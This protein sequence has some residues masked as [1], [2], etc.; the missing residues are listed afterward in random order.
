MT[1]SNRDRANHQVIGAA[2]NFHRRYDAQ[3]RC[4][5]ARNLRNDNK[6]L[7]RLRAQAQARKLQVRATEIHIHGE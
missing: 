1:R 3:L 6:R 2:S 4:V 5:R 7:E